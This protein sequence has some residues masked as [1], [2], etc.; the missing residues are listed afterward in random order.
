MTDQEMMAAILDSFKDPVL[1]TDTDH[2]VRYMNKV[3]MSF[4]KEGKDLIGKSLFNCHNAE[5]QREIIDILAAMRAGKVEERLI[6]DNEEKRVYMRAVRDQKGQVI[7][8]Y[9]RYELPGNQPPLTFPA[10][11]CG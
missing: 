5:S 11:G 3:A 1:F 2:I 7:G 10:N 8:Y 6:T 9:E 4:Y